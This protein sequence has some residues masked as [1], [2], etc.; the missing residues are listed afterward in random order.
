MVAAALAALAVSVP[1]GSARSTSNSILWN[2][3]GSYV[4]THYCAN[5]ACSVQF[6]LPNGTA[7]Q[8]VCYTDT[9]WTYGNYWSP[10]WFLVIYTHLWWTNYTWV[11]SSYVYYQTSVPHC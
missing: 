8:M 7:V 6:W 10:R 9:V 5:D 3:S 4:P 1:V 2:Q 11:H